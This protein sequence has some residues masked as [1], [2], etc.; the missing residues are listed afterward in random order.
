[1]LEYSISVFLIFFIVLPFSS[2]SAPPSPPPKVVIRQNY[3]TV[4][5]E[6]EAGGSDVPTTGYQVELQRKSDSLISYRIVSRNRLRVRTTGKII[7]FKLCC[8]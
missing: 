1:M 2:C 5:I 8:S 7:N 4:S 3:P 6:W